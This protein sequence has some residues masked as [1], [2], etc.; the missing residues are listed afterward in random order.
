MQAVLVAALIIVGLIFIA[1]GLLRP[2]F[3]FMLACG[4][5]DSKSDQ[6]SVDTTMDN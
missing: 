3:N 4:T 6:V 1:M 2:D 5:P